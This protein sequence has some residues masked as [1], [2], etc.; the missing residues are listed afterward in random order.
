MRNVRARRGTSAATDSL[1]PIARGSHLHHGL[2]ALEVLAHGPTSAAQVAADLDVNRST[3]LRLLQELESLG[4][5]RRN[6]RTKQYALVSERFLPMVSH[7]RHADWHELI[8]PVLERIRDEVGE[9]TIFATPVNGV[10]V[11]VSFYISMKSVAV[12]EQIGTV[13]PMH[14]SAIGK[15]WLSA[16]PEEQ[17]EIE[18]QRIDYSKGTDK[19]P[20]G[21]DELREQVTAFAKRGWATDIEET[22]EGASCVAVPSWINNVPV[23]A[24][25]I[26]APSVRID[27]RAIARY[28][29]LLLDA[30]ASI[31]QATA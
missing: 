20:S 23:G 19:A 22:A 24:V 2:R 26:S 1:T 12:R 25:S 10:M 14:A 16:L 5:V 9:S 21:P 27:D 29:R 31:R 18:L 11:H 7:D 28:G 13:R 8:N 6:A 4:F 30:M 15:A 3:G 17:L